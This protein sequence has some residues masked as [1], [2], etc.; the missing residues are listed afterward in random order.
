M[1]NFCA[2]FEMLKHKAGLAD[3]AEKSSVM[4]VKGY[5]SHNNKYLSSSFIMFYLYHI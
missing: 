2:V 4:M 3:M 1:H 5:I